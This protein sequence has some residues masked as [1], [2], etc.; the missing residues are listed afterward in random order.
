ME[1]NLNDYKLSEVKDEC[2][3]LNH[4][5]SKCRFEG[6]VC[7]GSDPGDWCFT[8]DFPI[9]EIN[10]IKLFEAAGVK[11]IARDSEG[12]IFGYMNAPQF[13][14]NENGGLFT[15]GTSENGMS[16]E[17]P[18]ETFKSITFEES[19]VCLESVNKM[20]DSRISNKGE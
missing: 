3:R 12:S 2:N 20:V 4:N 17:L 19:P 10:M 14:K 8:V 6:L 11:Y 5:C 13:I 1:R 16:Y 15:S 7:H 9:E 18:R